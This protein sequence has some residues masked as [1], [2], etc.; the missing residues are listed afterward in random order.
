[1]FNISFKSFYPPTFVPA[2]ARKL[3]FDITVQILTLCTQKDTIRGS[4]AQ[5][6]CRAD[7]V[8]LNS[9]FWA[10]NSKNLF[11]PLTAIPNSNFRSDF[12]LGDYAVNVDKDI[13]KHM[14]QPL[15]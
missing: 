4:L 11:Y 8:S 3:E 6:L 9:Y 15:I 12:F 2:A 13:V 14:M 1:M 7:L 10:L 5:V